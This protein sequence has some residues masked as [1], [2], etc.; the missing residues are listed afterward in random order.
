MI[1]KILGCS[2]GIG[3]AMRT[4]SLLVDDDVLIDAGTGVNDCSLDALLKIDHIFITHSHLDHITSIPLL[5]DTV[6]GLRTK[7]ITVHASVEVINSLKQHIFNWIIWPNF[8]EI[9]N[10]ENPFLCYNE[11][12]VGQTVQIGQKTITALPAN[13]VVPAMGYQIDSGKNSLVFTGDTAECPEFWAAVNLITNLKIL[14]IETA[15]SNAESKLALLSKHLC[16]ATLAQQ[17]ALLNSQPA[18]YITHLKP[19]EDTT[20]MQEIAA[21]PVTQNCIALVQQ[22]IFTL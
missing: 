12:N 9:P 1:I 10:T 3:G 11:I 13:H 18:I 6:M 14:I 8:N 17:L 4:T 22:Q 2:G 7:P 16:P 21:N 20:I 15:F 19:G 5:L